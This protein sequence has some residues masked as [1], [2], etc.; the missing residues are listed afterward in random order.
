M[1]SPHFFCESCGAE[2]LLAARTCPRCGK[3]FQAVRCPECG[4]VG[5][6]ALFSQGCPVCGFTAVSSPA[7]QVKIAGK[8]VEKSR[9]WKTAEALPLWVYLLA[10]VFFLGVCGI[11]VT[12]L[13]N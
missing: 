5:E 10:A 8:A 2:V 1:K 13:R 6:E 11:L 9:K 7:K 4:C 3:S 12:I